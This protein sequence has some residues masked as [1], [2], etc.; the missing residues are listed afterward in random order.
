MD[1]FGDMRRLPQFRVQKDL[2]IETRVEASNKPSIKVPTEKMESEFECEPE[3]E[4]EA[5]PKCG[6]LKHI[7]TTRSARR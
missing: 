1:V 4:P 7:L 3:P 5:N 6:T 2:R